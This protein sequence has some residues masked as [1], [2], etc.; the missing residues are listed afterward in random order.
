MT[1]GDLTYRIATIPG[2]G[3]GPEDV[4]DV[5]VAAEG[6]R[7]GLLDAID[8]YQVN[9]ITRDGR[10]MKAAGHLRERR[11]AEV[12]ASQIQAAITRAIPVARTQAPAAVA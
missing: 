5:E 3:V 1:E 7:T 12:A 10:K 9:L 8:Y 6:L 11:A 2:D 4:A